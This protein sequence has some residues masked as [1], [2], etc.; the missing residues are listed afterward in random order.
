MCLRDIPDRSQAF[1]TYERLRRAR[2]ERMVK[3]GR[4][5]GQAKIVTQPI[6]VGFRDMLTPLFLKLFANRAALDWVYSY[7]ANWD[8]KA[9]PMPA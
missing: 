7:T 2:V 8:E 3:Y 5:T 6:Q 4:S 1:A 9:Q